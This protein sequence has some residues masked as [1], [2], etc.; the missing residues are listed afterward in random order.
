M[1]ADA[2]IFGVN[3]THADKM[4]AKNNKVLETSQRRIFQSKEGQYCNIVPSPSLAPITSYTKPGVI[5]WE[6]QVHLLAAWEEKSKISM[7]NDA[8]L[9]Y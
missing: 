6:S 4:N 8:V 2:D 9:Y 1:E 3:E 5:W 7:V